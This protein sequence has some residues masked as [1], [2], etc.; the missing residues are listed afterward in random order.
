[1]LD[2]VLRLPLEMVLTESFAFVDRQQALDRMGLALRRLRA[3]DDDA[4]S[5]RGELAAARDDVGAGR[6][7]YGEHHLTI[8]A[9]PRPS[10]RST[11]A[12]ADVQSALAETGAI[13]VREDINLEPAFWAQFPGN[14][15]FIARKAHG[16]HRQFRQPRQLP[17]PPHRP[18]R[19]AITGA[20]PSRCWR[21]PPSAPTTSTSI[22]ATSAT[23]RSS[24][25]R[26]RARRCC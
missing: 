8:L 19:A 7:A 9:K 2:G 15:K 10:R 18:G 6:A 3:A 13:A 11:G 12:V 25:R 26:A 22:T 5:L 20:R 17:Q 14:F 23:S 4:F 21:P 1:M 24:A 16:L